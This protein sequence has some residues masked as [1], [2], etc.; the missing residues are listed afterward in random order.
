[1]R[2][3]ISGSSGMIGSA[4]VSALEGEG[5]TIGRLVRRTANH[6]KNEVYWDPGRG[7]LDKTSLVDFAPEAV[8]NLAGESI[9]SGRWT[10]KKKAKIRDSRVHGSAVL[11]ESLASLENPPRVFINAS[12]IG[13][14]GNRG[15]EK[16]SESSPSGEGFLAEVCRA[17]EVA[18]EPAQ[19]KGIRVVL[20]RTGIVLDLHGGALKKMLLPFKLGLGGVIGNGRQYM[21]WISIEDEVGI[22]QFAL[23]HDSLQGPVNAV[24]PNPV[25][26][27]EFTKT[28][29]RVLFRPTLVP[30]PASTARMIFGEKA[31]ELL[32]AGARVLPEKLLQ[33]GYSFKYPELK[34]ALKYLL[35]K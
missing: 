35:R 6:G 24:A 20:V 22:L 12:A 10:S 2:I 14:Y 30:M 1:M 16:L 4:L 28:L 8:I 5:H 15:Q 18:T 17:W 23:T 31:E 9:A 26:N 29:G 19:K 33:A 34:P 21:S 27:R 25:T 11:A 3:L 7:S 32:L 13:F